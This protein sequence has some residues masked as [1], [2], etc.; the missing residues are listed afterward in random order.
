VTADPKVSSLRLPLIVV[1]EEPEMAI[2][3]AKLNVL[4]GMEFE[5]DAAQIVR[6]VNAHDG[7]V[8]ALEAYIEHCDCAMP[9]PCDLDEILEAIRADKGNVDG[10]C[11]QCIMAS[12]AL[13]A[14]KEGA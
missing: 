2:L 7:L 14:A 3:D 5:T 11:A 10:W 4:A 1:G 12:A 6:C 9:K 8:E 13:A